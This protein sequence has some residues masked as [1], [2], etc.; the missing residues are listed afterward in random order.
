[1]NTAVAE[2]LE[3]MYSIF[4]AYPKPDRI[5]GCPCCVSD[6]DQA[7]LHTE[8][9]RELQN[10][11]QYAFKAISTWGSVEDFKHFLPRVFE[12]MIGEGFLTDTF[13][14]LG[15]LAFGGWKDWPEVEQKGIQ[16]F[17]QDWW[18]ELAACDR[19]RFADDA[20]EILPY[21]PFL[22]ALLK[23]WQLKLDNQ[24][25]FNLAHLVQY[26]YWD[27]HNQE[28][29]FKHLTDAE[30]RFFTQWLKAQKPSLEEGFFHFAN[31]SPEEAKELSDAHATMDLY[32]Q[33]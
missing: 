32:P 13:V 30:S 14:V 19:Y 24:S 8:P 3:Q 20:M 26:Q 5:E 25:L 10:L 16:R 2:S 31:F 7:E 22:P 11:D 18:I 12:L 23:Q 33:M 6:A 27:I 15:K 17:L 4:S 1:M 21:I 28:G 9:L 29:Y